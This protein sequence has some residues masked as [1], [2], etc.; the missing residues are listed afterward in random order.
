MLGENH[1]STIDSMSNLDTSYH[2]QGKYKDAEILLKECFDKMK[3]LH[4]DNHPDTL[5]IVNNLQ[6]R[7]IAKL[8]MISRVSG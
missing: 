5:S 8:F 1:S 3:L 7:E 4:G 6:Q 2:H